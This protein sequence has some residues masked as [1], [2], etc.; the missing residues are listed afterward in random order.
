MGYIFVVILSYL[1]GSS[2]MA[3]YLSRLTGKDIKGKGSRNLGTSNAVIVIGWRWGIVVGIHD[4]GKAVVSILLARLFFPD[5]PLIGAVAG[6]SCVLGHIFPFYLRFQGGKGFAP[7]IGMTLMLN[8]KLA[9]AVL[10]AVVIITV[11]TDYLVL[12]TAATVLTVPVYL[13][14]SQKSPL[15]AVILLAASVVILYKHRENYLRI[16]KG[17]EIGLR[18]TL[19]KNT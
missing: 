15:L 4:I 10:A 18:K 12:G 1:L 13:G 3:Y 9:L 7:Y 19:K 2:N 14:L 6:V 16:W 8:W 5:L 11:V 17:T